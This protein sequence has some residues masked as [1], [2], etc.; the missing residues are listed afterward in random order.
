LISK[1]TVLSARSPTISLS[2]GG[3]LSDEGPSPH[4]FFWSRW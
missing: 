1:E 4:G 3:L 2:F